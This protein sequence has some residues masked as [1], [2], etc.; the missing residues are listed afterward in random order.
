MNFLFTT[1]KTCVIRIPERNLDRCI[2]F[3]CF[4][5]LLLIGADRWGV[6]FVGVNFRLVQ[7]FLCSLSFLLIARNAFYVHA[8]GFLLA[9]AACALISVCFCINV[10]RGAL[11]YCSIVYNI[12]FLFFTVSSY[13][14][15]YGLNRFIQIFRASCYIQFILIFFQFFLKTAFAYELPFLPAYDEYFGIPRFQLWFYEPS[16]LATFLVFWFALSFY[17]FLIEEQ[18]DYIPDILFSLV[19]FLISTSTSG[20]IGVA[21]TVAAVYLIW[22]FKGASLKKLLFAAGVVALIILFRFAFRAL[23]D[24][25]IGRLF[26]ASLDDASGGRISGWTESWNVFLKNPAFGVGPGNYGLSLGKEAGYVPTNVTL[27]LLATLGIA[28]FCAFYGLTVSL[29]V[30]SIQSRKQNPQKAAPLAALAFALIVFTIILQ[31]NQGYLRLYHW[32]FF[33]LMDGAICET[34]LR[35]DLKGRIS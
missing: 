26:N 34:R 30:K 11:Y 5:S 13:V 25:F 3:F 33:G 31:F 27:D 21:L 32:M 24:V 16:Y 20:F 35:R 2:H 17:M 29:A 23:F 10:L 15:E 28:G 8:D 6:T 18:R 19:M 22:L 4:L 1:H 9:F 12:V 14:Q 7:L